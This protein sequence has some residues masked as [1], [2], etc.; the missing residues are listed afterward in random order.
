MCIRDR[1]NDNDSVGVEEKEYTLNDIFDLLKK[2][3][4]EMDKRMNKGFDELQ[5]MRNKHFDNMNKGFDELH[6]ELNKTKEIMSKGCDTIKNAFDK[7]DEKWEGDRYQIKKNTEVE[8]TQVSGD[9]A[10]GNS[11]EIINQVSDNSNNEL[12]NNSDKI[13]EEIVLTSDDK[14][15]NF[16][17]EV[18]RSDNYDNISDNMMLKNN[19]VNI[20]ST[21]EVLECNYG[22]LVCVNGL[23]LSLIHI[24]CS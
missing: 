18:S 14:K 21:D 9:N 7:P 2:G 3:F 19:G 20:E 10:F 24:Y 16:N 5:E 23:R 4:D 1:P 11:E 8:L 15:G 17:S 6:I 13:V 12:I 22:M